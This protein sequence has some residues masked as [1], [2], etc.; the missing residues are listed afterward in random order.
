MSAVTTRLFANLDTGDL[1]DYFGK[2]KISGEL[3]FKARDAAV[4]GIQFYRGVGTPVLL[5]AGSR[6]TFAIAGKKVYGGTYLASVAYGGFT[7]A[8]TTEATGQTDTDF[9]RGA[10]DLDQTA[11]TTAIGDSLPGIDGNAEVSVDLGAATRIFTTR[12][13]PVRI[14]NDV[15]RG[16]EA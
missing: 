15:V 5:E 7:V 12:T 3:F 14:E 2:R 6:V 8:T 13:I 10:L 11:I 1:S 9:Y 16:T 4:I